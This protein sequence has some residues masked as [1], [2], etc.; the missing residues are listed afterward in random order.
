MH[1]QVN[2]KTALAVE[3]KKTRKM[4]QYTIIE[5]GEVDV[6][7]GLTLEYNGGIIFVVKDM[8]QRNLKGP[9]TR[10]IN[11]HRCW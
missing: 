8:L 10:N 2:I 1:T 5:E 7:E 11:L 6:V 9:E 3:T 4:D